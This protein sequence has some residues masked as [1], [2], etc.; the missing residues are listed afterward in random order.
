MNIRPVQLADAAEWLRLRVALWPDDPEKE[1]AEI[2]QL[3][4][5]AFTN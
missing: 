2:T 3:W 5:I 4:I 1:A